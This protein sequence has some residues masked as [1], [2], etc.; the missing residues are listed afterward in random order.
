MLLKY[1]STVII[2]LL[3]AN[4]HI[5]SQN[6][7][8]N[9]WEVHT[10][11]NTTTT[12]DRDS[13]NRIWVGSTGGIAIFDGK[14]IIEQNTNNENTI[15][16]NANNGLLNPSIN[17]IKHIPDTTLML[18]GSNNGIIE[19]IDENTL[20]SR[21]ITGI[22][23]HNFSNPRINDFL[24]LPR[25]GDSINI[26]I[27]GGFGIAGFNLRRNIF[28]N[29]VRT[30][31]NFP[32]D[33]PV[34]NMIIHNDSIWVATSLGLAKISLKDQINI[35]SNWKTYRF[36][37]PHSEAKI[38]KI[39]NKLYTNS[40]TD[41]FEFRNDSFTSVY[42]I[43]A[44]D[45][46]N[47]IG[48]YGGKLT[49]STR[50]RINRIEN[51]GTNNL[52]TVHSQNYPSA[53]RGFTVIDHPQIE[54]VA[55]YDLLGSGFIENDFSFTVKTPNTPMTNLFY[56]LV[57]DKNGKLFA[58]SEDAQFDRSGNAYV[59]YDGKNW[60]NYHPQ[61][62]PSYPYVNDHFVSI[63]VSPDNKVYVGSW[64]KGLMVMDEND[65]NNV[66]YTRYDN[67]NS[68]LVEHAGNT[69]FV[70]IGQ[71]A[72]D[73][74]G[75][76]WVVN[77]GG[78]APENM[79]VV[80]NSDGSSVGFN[81][82]NPT[83]NSARGFNIAID[84]NNTKWVG[85]H[86]NGEGGLY[87]FNER[88]AGNLTTS[89]VPNLLRNWFTSIVYDR[90]MNLVWLGTANGLAVINNPSAVLSGS[91][92]PNLSITVNRLLEGQHIN[93]IF[94]DAIGNKWI[95]TR[96]GIWVLSIDGSEVIARFTTNNTPLFSNNIRA[97]VINPENG[98]VY[99]GTGEG[100]FIANGTVLMPQTE[101][102]ITVY[103][104]P[105][106]INR[107]REIVIEGL[108]TDSDIRIITPDGILVRS[109]FT[110]SRRAVWDGKD[111]NGNTVPPGV[112]LIISSSTVANTSG[113][114]KI[115]VVK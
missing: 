22:R 1:F 83:Q 14:N 95:S 103:P 59:G 101:Y 21:H 69:N 73:S 9:N 33:T 57:L 53:I 89:T 110:S 25:N 35:P 109:I 71:T 49:F 68:V 28:T 31:G 96:N 97:I 80:F 36:A 84:A 105:F 92:N 67:T 24:I 104:Q 8:L 107:D 18:A 91:N 60:T 19:I 56:S 81:N 20:R 3:F 114:G 64:G 41:I 5:Y 10:T 12:A 72:F 111:N 17:I 42:E 39:D 48:I 32:R 58:V 47:N 46:I 115:A 94:I 54:I 13:K 2:L 76:A 79:L 99:I 82:P 55:F 51:I 100:L 98:L 29:T 70:I 23:D 75:R 6:I 74:Q 93:N 77:I 78:D 15:L 30:I 86:F 66:T 65:K 52:T 43:S 7:S 62:L 102:S 106:N 108:T 61:L 27:A 44:S 4:F 38:V 45:A 85:N 34:N 87:Y 50:Y 88:V 112:Y 40:S 90:F 37:T 26:L 11:M 16:I 63:A 113:A